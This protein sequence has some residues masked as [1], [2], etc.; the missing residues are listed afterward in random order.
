MTV[1]SYIAL[2]ASLLALSLGLIS[3]FG[4]RGYAF[5]LRRS[6]SRRS[7]DRQG[8]RRDEDWARVGVE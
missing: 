2:I 4:E 6:R 8:G 5:D 1:L 7:K 3:F